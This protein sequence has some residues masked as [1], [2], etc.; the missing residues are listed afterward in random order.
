MFASENRAVLFRPIGAEKQVAHGLAH[1]QGKPAAA[2]MFGAIVQHVTA[3]AEGAQVPQPVIG[4]VVIKM[5]G[6]Q[7]NPCGAHRKVACDRLGQAGEL[8]AVS[9][10]PS[11]ALFVPPS[12]VAEM[13]H[14]LSMRPAALLASALGAFEPY[15]ER[16]VAA[17]RS[18][19]AI[20]SASG[21][22]SFASSKAA[23][24]SGRKIAVER[25]AADAE[26]LR[27]VGHRDRGLLQQGAGG[28][29]VV[30]RQALRPSA[31]LSARQGGF[32][33]LHGALSVQVEEVFGHR[34]VHLQGEA[35]VGSV[36]VEL[37]CQ[38]LEANVLAAERDSIVRIISTRERPSRSSFQTIS[39][40]S[41]RRKAIAASNSGRLVPAFP[42]FLFLEQLVATC[43]HESI[44]LQVEVLVNGRDAGIADQH[45]PIVSQYR[46][47]DNRLVDMVC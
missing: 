20:C 4:R 21:S 35:P 23:G 2:L 43:L 18:G 19:T 44:A 46:F 27:D 6:G 38:A 5:R 32:Q 1:A 10:A 42:D 8:P 25:C 3:L 24:A 45:V 28:G 9:V 12:T 17:S 14:L 26:T 39:T 11:P 13:A 22:A 33:P 30:F 40:S 47:Q 15:Q 36:A 41:G 34:T 16:R 31:F 29:K 37:L 7:N